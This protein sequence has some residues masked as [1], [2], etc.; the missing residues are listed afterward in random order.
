MPTIWDWS[1]FVG[2]IGLF[3]ALFFVFIRL[4]PVISIFELRELVPKPE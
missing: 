1:T 2:T 3:L 4:L